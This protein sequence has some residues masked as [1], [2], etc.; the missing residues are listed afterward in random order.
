MQYTMLDRKAE[1]HEED[2]STKF[3]KA[4]RIDFSADGYCYQTIG[5][6]P[7]VQVPALR[8]LSFRFAKQCRTTDNQTLS[9]H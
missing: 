7:A 9:G 6:P 8:A 3:V 1:A 5:Q 4:L 2:G